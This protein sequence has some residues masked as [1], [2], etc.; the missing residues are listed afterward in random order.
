VY[1]GTYYKY[2]FVIYMY[3]ASNSWGEWKK[4]YAYSVMFLELYAPSIELV[5]V[6]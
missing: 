4:A 6:Q 3:Q 5:E 2:W 1:V